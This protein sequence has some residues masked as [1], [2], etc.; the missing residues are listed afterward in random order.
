MEE[1]TDRLKIE[2]SQLDA[3][4]LLTV[5]AELEEMF[6]AVNKKTSNFVKEHL[7]FMEKVTGFL[8]TFEKYLQ[9]HP[10][11]NEDIG[12]LNEKMMKD[13]KKSIKNTEEF[14]KSVRLD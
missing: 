1:D 8:K 6:A 9:E 11:L 12:S 3:D 14:K 10:E 2:E 5:K 13:V 4:Q 7:E